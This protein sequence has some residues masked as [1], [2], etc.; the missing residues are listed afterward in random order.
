MPNKIHE[1][2]PLTFSLYKSYIHCGFQIKLQKKLIRTK[3]Y[4]FYFFHFEG[5][6][7]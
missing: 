4:G 5:V 3:N 7:L 6:D 2:S 1:F